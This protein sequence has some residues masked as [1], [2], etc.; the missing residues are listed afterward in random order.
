[1]LFSAPYILLLLLILPFY[2]LNI[3]N[4]KKLKKSIPFPTFYIIKNQKKS[5]KTYF[6]TYSSYINTFILFLLILALARPQ[7]GHEIKETKLK[8]V[9]IVLA[10]DTSSSML[11]QDIGKNRIETAKN[12][13]SKFVKKQDNNRLG[14]VTFSGKSFTLSPL[15]ND[16]EF[17][18]EQLDLV[19]TEIV[20]TGG[21]AIGDAIANGTYIFEKIKNKSKVI[22]LLTDGENN[23]GQISPIRAS[24]IAK[25]KGIKIYTIGIGKPEGVPLKIVDPKTG[26]EEYQKDIRG[27]II[28]TKINEEE[29]KEIAAMTNGE[30]FSADNA[31]TLDDIYSKINSLEK[32]EIITKNYKKFSEKFHYFLI[33]A[34]LIIFIVFI[35]DK[36]IINPLKSS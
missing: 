34:V 8:G 1:M 6:Y 3:V 5:W 18:L 22:I 32:S 9:D 20:K 21:T 4:K 10:I 25:T 26:I 12:V 27:E 23:M 35:L 31:K 13:I 11:A 28:I 33:P 15:T 14:L 36:K 16:Y 17:I 2:H 30:Y 19:N 7:V 29:L 24:E